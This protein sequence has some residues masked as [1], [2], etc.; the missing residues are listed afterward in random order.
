MATAKVQGSLKVYA[1]RTYICTVPSYCVN[2]NIG[3]SLGDK[4]LPFPLLMSTPLGAL[5]L[6][7]S[8]VKIWST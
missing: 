7:S 1:C 3:D 5:E 4:N 6:V 2:I 8:L